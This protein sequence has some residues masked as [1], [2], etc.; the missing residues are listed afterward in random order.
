[1]IEVPMP[2]DANSTC[3]GI[4]VS[5]AAIYEQ[6]LQSLNKK[7]SSKSVFDIFKRLPVYQ[8]ATVK[9][10]FGEILGPRGKSSSKYCREPTLLG[11]E[12]CRHRRRRFL[13]KI[14]SFT[15]F[16]GHGPPRGD[17]VI[18]IAWRPW[19]PEI[20]LGSYASTHTPSRDPQIRRGTGTRRDFDNNRGGNSATRYR[21]YDSADSGQSWDEEYIVV[22][23]RQRNLN[24]DII[25]IE[26]RPPSPPPPRRWSTSNTKYPDDPQ[27]VRFPMFDN[28]DDSIYPRDPART[29][30][31]YRPSDGWRAE[32]S[33]SRVSRP[34]T[35]FHDRNGINDD[36]SGAPPRFFR[37]QTERYRLRSTGDSYNPVLSTNRR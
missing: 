23:R 2:W 4:P 7:G 12:I 6:A 5:S 27:R 34:N 32:R 31:A 18:W 11:L 10:H 36:R 17:L 1:M 3:T 16:Y 19:L 14:K 9:K 28:I 26:R 22:P 35:T 13:E 33:G 20:D 21:N 29:L 8:Q 37:P 15:P 30:D 24:R 25:Q